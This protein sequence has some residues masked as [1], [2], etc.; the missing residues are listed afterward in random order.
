MQQP[1]WS[2]DSLLRSLAPR[3]GLSAI[4]IYLQGAVASMP[5]TLSAQSHPRQKLL[6]RR[7]ISLIC[8]VGGFVGLTSV[9]A[10]CSS[11]AESGSSTATFATSTPSSFSNEELR[12]YAKVILA[13]EPIR[14][15]AYREIQRTTN[16]GKVPPVTCNQPD[17]LASLPKDIQSIAANYCNQAKKIGESNG[18]TMARFNAITT[19]AQS[20]LDL[21]RRIQNEFTT[22]QR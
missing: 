14:Q 20:D 9:L 11:A 22:L 21:Q 13:I 1:T 12:N 16:A 15:S 6:L 7:I 17:S 5:H 19:N 4:L 18:L 2:F 8:I 3:V 10:G